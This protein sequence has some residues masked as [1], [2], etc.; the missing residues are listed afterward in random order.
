MT[1]KSKSLTICFGRLDVWLLDLYGISTQNSTSD[2]LKLCHY[3]NLNNKSPAYN[4]ECLINT[5]DM[6]GSGVVSLVETGDK[7]SFCLVK[8]IQTDIA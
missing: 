8:Q 6:V 3:I 7:C 1:P 2:D 4:A 5:H